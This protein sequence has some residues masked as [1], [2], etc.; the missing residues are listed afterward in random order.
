MNKEEELELLE[1]RKRCMAN[2]KILAESKFASQEIK[3]MYR[4]REILK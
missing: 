2:L 3:D 4:T 1:I